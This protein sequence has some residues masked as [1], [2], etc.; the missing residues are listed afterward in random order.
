MR[1]ISRNFRASSQRSGWYYWRGTYL[2]QAWQFMV[3]RMISLEIRSKMR[4]SICGSYIVHEWCEHYKEFLKKKYKMGGGLGGT[5][6]SSSYTSGVTYG[7][8]I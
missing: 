3:F 1:N 7:G 2:E 4:C 8:W 5:V 6:S